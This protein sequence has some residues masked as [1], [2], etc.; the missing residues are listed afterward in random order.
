MADLTIAAISAT[1]SL[2]LGTGATGQ[3]TLS[4][5]SI[6]AI[7]NGFRSI[8]YGLAGQQGNITF[9][10]TAHSY[11]SSV[12]VV[13][14]SAPAVNILT[15]I[16]TLANN[17]TGQSITIDGGNNTVTT[18]AG[19]LT[20]AGG[21]VFID[22]DHLLLTGPIGRTINTG[23]INNQA[24][25]GGDVTLNQLKDIRSDANR[26]PFEIDTRGT[27]GGGNVLLADVGIFGQVGHLAIHT[28]P[29]NGTAGILTLDD[30]T[31][32]PAIVE[33]WSVGTIDLSDASIVLADRVE[34]HGAD[35]VIGI[36]LGNISSTVP[37]ADLDVRSAS[38]ISLQ[39]VNI[40]GDLSI[41]VDENSDSAGALL[42][43][44]SSIRA[45]SIEI[46]G[47]TTST[48]VAA[49]S[50]TLTSIVGPITLANFS[51][52][53]L[54]GDVT[55]A[56]QLQFQ[57][58]THELKLLSGTDLQ[59][60]GSLSL[61]PPNV[62]KVRLDGGSGTTNQI[63]AINDSAV[64]TVDGVI[65][66]NSGIGL[67]LISDGSVSIRD[68]NLGSTGSLTVKADQD[69]DT[70]NSQLTSQL[71]QAGSIDFSG[72]TE[73]N[74]RLILQDIHSALSGNLS[75][76][77]F[78]NLQINQNL[79]AAGN[80]SISNISGALTVAGGVEVSAGGD[81]TVATGVN[82]ISLAGATG[83]S[84]TFKSTG[85]TSQIDLANLTGLNTGS[86]LTVDSAG[87]VSLGNV[88][89]LSQSQLIIFVDSDNDSA[90]RSLNAGSLNAGSIQ[91]QGGN[92][93]DDSATLSST[94][95][96]TSGLIEITQFNQLT[97]S[98]DVTARGSL[99]V[100]QIQG[101]LSLGTGVDLR[102]QTGDV[103]AS[104]AVN[105]INLTSGGNSLH[106]FQST[107]GS[108]RL[109]TVF[110][111]GGPNSVTVRAGMDAFITA[112]SIQESLTII[113]D[114]DQDNVGDI[115][116]S[117]TLSA[118]S[119]S[120]TAGSGIGSASALNT[121]TPKL[122]AL[123]RGTGDVQI[124]NALTN[125]VSVDSLE[126][127]GGGNL[128]FHQTGGGAVQFNSVKT[129]ADA[130]PTLGESN[131]ELANQGGNLVI[132]DAGVNAGG[133]GQITL[134]T[135]TPGLVIVSAP[136]IADGD[137]VQITSGN[138]IIGTSTI[139]ARRGELVAAN[140]IGSSAT[141]RLN[142]NLQEI[143]ARSQNTSVFLS[144]S[145]TTPVVLSELLAAQRADLVQA[146]TGSLD[147]VFA[148]A[149]NGLN[150]HTN[151]SPMTISG[152]A[153]AFTG[154]VTLTSTRDITLHSNA[155][156]ETVSTTGRIVVNTTG[157]FVFDP[158]AVLLAGSG[159][160]ATRAVVRQLIPTVNVQ[161][162]VNFLGVNLDTNGD[163]RLGLVFPGP[164]GHEENFKIVVDWGDGQIDTFPPTADAQGNTRF[165]SNTPYVFTHQYAF[166]PGKDS[167]AN[168]PFIV[169]VT[170][171][172][173]D[174]IS[175][176]AANLA[177]NQVLNREVRG[178]FTV[179]SKGIAEMLVVSGEVEETVTVVAPMTHTMQ[180]VTEQNNVLLTTAFIPNS[181]GGD[182]GAE[183]IR[184]YV[185]RIVLAGQGESEDIPLTNEALNDLDL[186]FGRLADDHYRIYLIKEDGTEQ[187]MKDVFLRNHVP[188]ETDS[189]EYGEDQ[190]QTDT[191]KP[192]PLNSPQLHR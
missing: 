185:L 126:A 41:R 93:L 123:N 55:S 67:T 50:D 49:F 88:N 16:D 155:V 149:G 7:G 137:I 33:I 39:Q 102:S 165:V 140:N 77:N 20:T 162:V 151:Q 173:A 28:V 180:V 11:S 6:A 177:N 148:S 105:R 128:V 108:V 56:G 85:D 51:D 32:G 61:T 22:G 84:T 192:T 117:G 34:M 135:T 66:T 153:E 121:S 170:A 80:L 81:L 141:T 119:I 29:L 1:G 36:R 70:V 150:I 48:T 72:G 147:V 86:N 130:T 186:L 175:L 154:N 164:Q 178:E 182:A 75:I 166:N 107:Q 129:I 92:D 63:K 78:A 15:N 125:A 21:D 184:K 30:T 109:P 68:I 76:N 127:R 116:A 82:Q 52:L 46:I 42:S 58:I 18:L 87:D 62:A 27:S 14:T 12:R 156:L 134:T 69:N 122:A 139:T 144:N 152:N 111:G 40:V 35:E 179:P 79:S 172:A 23:G 133:A 2:G 74:D 26:T 120:L 96:S 167:A 189:A 95:T 168:I 90:A 83:T 181:L 142:T 131:I 143:V 176:T 118:K 187:L 190:S 59:F 64:L 124:N 47:N 171:D 98:G 174:R 4:D 8:I 161:P 183:G 44:S 45:A 25:L 13:A 101:D 19:N 163:V 89:L 43:A 100:G 37:T 136:I 115:G 38:E 24:N 94:S 65:A 97:I 138:G 146:G 114:D 3:V 169:R 110:D 113:A 91:V 17:A 158:G 57:G 73:K 31:P 157:N 106:E 71:I 9:A 53:I 132:S 191:G 99:L 60:T 145:S 112:T 104:Q 10:G 5:A 103:D 188:V 159:N 160:L 54:G